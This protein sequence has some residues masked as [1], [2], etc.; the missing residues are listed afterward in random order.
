MSM[1]KFEHLESAILA[2]FGTAKWKAEA[3]KTF[4]NNFVGDSAGA[5]Y[6]RVSIITGGL[7]ANIKSVSGMLNIDVFTPV[8]KGPTKAS[9]IADKLDSYLV[10]QTLP[11]AVGVVQM[12]VSS[13]VH[14]GVD[15]A[16]PG[17]HHSLY[18]IPF[19]YFGV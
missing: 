16:N 9:I 17:L 13:F 14:S 2:V 12:A 18:T 1:G 6:I 15:A 19:N 7:G 4:P 11:A 3:I 5:A 8:G 10:G